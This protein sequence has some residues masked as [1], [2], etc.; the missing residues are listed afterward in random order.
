MLNLW[1]NQPDSMIQHPLLIPFTVRAL[2]TYTFK[3]V[4][5]FATAGVMAALRQHNDRIA[6]D[7]QTSS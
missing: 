1:L 4:V 7:P 5:D 6:N 2:L 3:Q